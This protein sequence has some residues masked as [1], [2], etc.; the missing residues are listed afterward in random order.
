MLA[1][2]IAWL[3][4]VHAVQGQLLKVL[5]AAPTIDQAKLLLDYVLKLFRSSP[6][7]TPLIR[8][9][10]ESPFPCV[11]V[12]ETVTIMVR[13]L[14]ERGRHLRGHGRDLGLAVLDEAFLVDEATVQEVVAPLLADKGGTLAIS[15]TATAP[16]GSYL[17]R[18][19]ER[20]MAG[21][22]RVGSYRFRSVDN[23]FVS[24]EY[25]LAQKKEITEEQWRV[26]WEGEFS[27]AINSV[28]AWDKVVACSEGEIGLSDEGRKRFV[29]GF[30]PAKVRD[31]SAIVILDCSTVPRRVVYLEDLHGRDYV[32]Q[33]TRVAELSTQFH[34]AKVT[35]DTTNGE[36]LA[37]L[38][39]ASGVHAVEPVNFSGGKKTELITTLICAVERGD[40]RFAPDERLLSEFRFFQAKRTPTGT[41]R[42]EAASQGH[43]DFVCALALSLHGAGAVHRSRPPALDEL[44]PFIGGPFSPPAGSIV[45]V[46]GGLDDR[47][48]SDWPPRG[49]W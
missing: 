22:G 35:I 18:L 28:F 20:G 8:R 12:G 17:H 14:A 4:V 45:S 38:L 44:P 42:Y 29:I 48:W 31:K 3:V 6:L 32:M 37:D 1:I 47:S 34:G 10:V 49:G 26:E 36:A 39:R 2:L 21:D 27:S 7:L 19:F 30:D 24:Q 11:E 25:I 13:S 43:D 15:S 41:I 40:I 46:P 9:H 33:A 5:I 16:Q 23:P